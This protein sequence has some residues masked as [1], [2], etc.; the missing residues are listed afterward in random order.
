MSWRMGHARQA[1]FD[2]HSDRIARRGIDLELTVEKILQ[3][4]QGTGIISS[5]THHDHN[6]YSDRCG[7]DFTV[8]NLVGGRQV[9][10]SFGVT[11]SQKS[12]NRSK[13]LHMGIPQWCLPVGTKRETIER[14]IL[15]LFTK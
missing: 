12:Q 14:K 6:S 7:C 9:E 11:I 13:V 5:F 8:R 3:D 10:R 15:G 4:M 2:R 1:F